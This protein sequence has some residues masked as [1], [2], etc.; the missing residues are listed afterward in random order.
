MSGNA[1]IAERFWPQEGLGELA[2]GH[3]ADVVLVDYDPP[4]PLDE[5]TLFGH[6]VFGVS[7]AAVDTTIVGGRV[8]MAG[9]KLELDIDEARGH[10]QGA[11]AVGGAVGEVL[12]TVAGGRWPVAGKAT[13]SR[14]GRESGV[15]IR[16]GTV[17]TPKGAR[18]AD[19]RVVGEAIAEIGDLAPLPGETVVD[20]AGLHVLPGMIDVHVHVDD[21]IGPYELADTFPTASEFARHARASP[22]SRGSSPSAPARR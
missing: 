17:W 15:L 7:Q 1:R 2:E 8:L 21:T 3:A 13:A 14:Y 4:T 9:K 11:R 5:G 16:G 20:A 18:R 10:G 22:R 12:K 19:V 6:L